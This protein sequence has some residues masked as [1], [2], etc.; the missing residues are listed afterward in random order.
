M[1]RVLL[2]VVLIL[3]ASAVASAQ[4]TFYFPHVVNG[5]QGSV[6]WKTTILLTNT[7]TT[8]AS[9]GITFSQDTSNSSA[10]GSPM[11]ITLT[12]E[13]G[14][15]G[16]G[17][18][19]SFSMPPNGTKRLISDGA[20][21][22][23]GG[24]ATVIPNTGR[25]SGT[26]I[27]SE[28][29]SAG[30]LIGEAGV[31]SASGVTR[32]AIFVDTINNYK[33]GVA[34]AN[35]SGTAANIK[36]DLLNSQAQS[37]L[38]TAMSQV[39]GPGNHTAG[40]TFQMFPSAPASMAGTMQITSDTPLAAV[41]LRFDPTLSKFTTLPPVSLASLINPALEWLQQRD[42]LTPLSSVARLLGALQLRIG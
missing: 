34:Y 36:L 13:A 33:I 16:S 27:F 18:A 21:P 19:F 2:T 12:D 25:V 28:F 26:A 42:W 10:G 14:G 3:T 17:S 11:T 9:G 20:G 5:V 24:F 30:N 35:P 31:P 8:T 1:K 40:F 32:Q 41:A 38:S 6:V 37:V 15:T 23:V 7:G 4:G 22:F 39:L 29:D